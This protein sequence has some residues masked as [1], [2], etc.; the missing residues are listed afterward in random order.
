MRSPPV[1]LLLLALLTPGAAAQAA[2][3]AVQRAPIPASP[4]PLTLADVLTRL[5]AGPGWR[6]ADLQ[7]R[8]AAL[9]LERARVQAGLNVT[10][11]ADVGAVKIPLS[12]GDLT[13]NTT[14]NAQAS[15]SVLPWSPAL[16]AVRSAERAVAGAAANL[17]ATQQTLAVNAVQA[18]YAARNAAASLAL[19]DAQLALS[20]RQLAVAQAQRAAGVLTEEGLLARQDALADAQAAQRQA[21]MNVDLAAR[22]LANLL[23]QSVTLPA[24][25]EAFGPLPP[26][27]QSPS[28]AEA[29]VTRALA[30]RP[31][32]ARAQNDLAD[33]QAQLRAAQRDARLPDL[34]ASVQYGQLATTQ[35]ETGRVVGGSL[36]VKT[37]VL[38]GQVSLPL[39]DP[40]ERPSGLALSLSGSFSVIGGG[41][42]PA[43]A[44]AEVS[45]ALAQAALESARQSVDLEVRQRSADLQTALDT[46]AS[47]RGALARAQAALVSTQARLA[48]GLATE[49]DVQAAQLNV[50]QTQLAVDNATVQAHLASL[51]LGQATGELDPTLL[52]LTP[53]APEARP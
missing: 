42:G 47:Q 50:M 4:S 43:L 14:V 30:T 48:A 36:N 27:P 31:E 51:R 15:A 9:T 49:L 22:G 8:Q 39:R 5:R 11:G 23:G 7:Y 34:T 18:Y 33:A 41:K 32:V 16:E 53:P 10:V 19:A 20:Q 6:A 40:G 44:A 17:R 46:L 3:P 45:V 38:A 1:L 52:I 25:A 21:R 24:D 29:L 26:V 2:P 28:S 12:T 13:L 35:A 37:G